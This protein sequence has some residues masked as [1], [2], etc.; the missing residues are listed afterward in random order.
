MGK[1]QTLDVAGGSPE[2]SDV[3]EMTRSVVAGVWLYRHVRPSSPALREINSSTGRQ[4]RVLMSRSAEPRS[5][6]RRPR[7]TSRR[8]IS[9]QRGTP[10]SRSRNS[11]AG[12]CPRRTSISTV[13][14]STTIRRAAAS[15]ARLRASPPGIRC[16]VAERNRPLPARFGSP[17]L[18]QVG[19]G[20]P[21][22]VGVDR[23]VDDGRP[24]DSLC[25]RPPRQEGILAFVQVDLSAPHDAR[26][27][28]PCSAATRRSG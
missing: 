22:Q 7:I 18:L 16:R 6:V 1:W 26:S 15:P 5:S 4:T 3:V 24:R 27:T 14:S 9:E 2:R 20:A 25:V 8:V 12:E 23:L 10:S 21:G 11:T 28:I 13:V 19:L 17:E